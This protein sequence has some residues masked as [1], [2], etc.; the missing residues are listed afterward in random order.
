MFAS[1]LSDLLPFV[2]IGYTNWA[3][4]IAKLLLELNLSDI[5]S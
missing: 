2:K 5:Q 1:D 3:L 4:L